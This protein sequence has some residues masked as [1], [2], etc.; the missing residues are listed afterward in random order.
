MRRE[1]VL[2]SS[3]VE[4]LLWGEAGKGTVG[5][6]GVVEVLEGVDVACDLGDGE[7]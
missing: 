2:G 7:G 4:V 3:F 6:V 5:S 1:G